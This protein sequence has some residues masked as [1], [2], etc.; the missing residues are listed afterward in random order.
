[1]TDEPQY[2]DDPMAIGVVNYLAAKGQIDASQWIEP[3]KSGYAA[4][5]A[6]AANVR[7]RADQKR[8]EAAEA[9]IAKVLEQRGVADTLA[10]HLATGGS[11]DVEPTEIPLNSAVLAEELDRILNG[12]D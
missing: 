9:E 6:A 10:W 3:K 4:L 8:R 7:A 11:V 2:L 12:D 5:A 1:M